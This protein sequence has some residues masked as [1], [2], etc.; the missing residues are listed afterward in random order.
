MV[1]EDNILHPNNLAHISFSGHTQKQKTYKCNIHT[2]QTAANVNFNK[3]I[4]NKRQ[5]T[6]DCL[7]HERLSEARTLPS[8]KSAR[9]SRMAD[10]ESLS[11][12]SS[13]QTVSMLTAT[14]VTLSE[15][16]LK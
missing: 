12:S 1:N 8:P 2:L 4:I 16:S 6:D 10:I 15:E 11:G 9:A 5:Q 3:A 13:C 14:S 7:H